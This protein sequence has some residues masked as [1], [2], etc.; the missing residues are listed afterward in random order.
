MKEDLRDGLLT[1]RQLVERD[2]SPSLGMWDCLGYDKQGDLW[3]YPGG[4]DKI[5]LKIED[6]AQ[7]H[8]PL[9]IVMPQMAMRRMDDYRGLVE[10]ARR[11][12]KYSGGIEVCYAT[13]AAQSAEIVMAAASRGPLEVSSAQDLYHIEWGMN[14]G[15]IPKGM[16]VLCNGHKP[17]PKDIQVPASEIDPRLLQVLHLQPSGLGRQPLYLE[18]I[19]DMHQRG[20]K[21]VPIIDSDSELGY[22]QS[23]VRK[24][25]EVGLRFKA[26][27]LIKNGFDA[28]TLISR[29]GFDEV[30][31]WQQADEITRGNENLKLK[32]FHA[33]VGAAETIKPEDM[34]KA[35]EICFDLYCRMKKKY[36]SFEAFN[37][38]GGV[39]P[40]GF[41]YDHEK[42]FDQMFAMFARKVKEYNIQA[43]QIQFE[44]GSPIAAEAGFTVVRVT[45]QKNQAVKPGSKRVSWVDIHGSLM[46]IIPDSWYIG[47]KFVMIPGNYGN[48]LT[49]NVVV[50]GT[51]CDSGDTFPTNSHDSVRV[52]KVNTNE[53]E[54]RSKLLLVFLKTQAYQEALAGGQATAHCLE[55]GPAEVILW[56]NKRGEIEGK[57]SPARGA[58]VMAEMMNFTPAQLGMLRKIASL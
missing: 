42:L 17:N 20:M 10:N 49:E 54:A 21:V 56:V 27:G 18:R 33:M 8:A 7:L 43:P 30:E 36:P 51:T 24:P 40:I 13:K 15:L 48:N 47:E 44:P 55:A 53:L 9:E 12:K 41:G 58:Q 34:V 45:E 28:K 19:V 50:G 26:Y 2:F 29:H 14:E 6:L 1:A 57:F 11:Q 31:M 37:I 32:V 22:L 4:K 35:L 16:E 3:V 23:R 25:M 52:P 5:G 46:N 39:P 38:G